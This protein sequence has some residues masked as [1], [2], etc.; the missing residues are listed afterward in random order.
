M[1]SLQETIQKDLIAAMKSKE[2]VRLSVL[3]M[4]KS[5]LQYELTKTGAKELSDADVEA[6]IKRGIKKRKES[7]EQFHKG[8]R[9]EMA[10]NE[11]AEI[12]ILNEYLPAALGAADIEKQL[13]ELLSSMSGVGPSD[14]GKVMGALM[15][16][17]KGQNVDGAL[18]K[19]IVGKRLNG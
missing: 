9:A 8:G 18:V 1:S 19:E 12:L 3:R 13:N 10:A 11:E 16:R 6:A 15:G 17:L 5:E 2:A 14:V 7:A 4:L